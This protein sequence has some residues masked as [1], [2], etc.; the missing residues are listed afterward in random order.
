MPFW[1]LLDTCKGTQQ[2][3]TIFKKNIILILLITVIGS[4]R[5]RRLWGVYT[6]LFIL[7]AALTLH[8]ATSSFA[9]TLRLRR[10]SNGIFSLMNE[11]RT[12][13]A[14]L[15][16]SDVHDQ[17][18]SIKE[19]S[20]HLNKIV[21]SN[22]T[23]FLAFSIL[24]FATTMDEVFLRKGSHEYVRMFRALFFYIDHAAVLFVSADACHQVTHP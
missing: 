12:S 1:L 21:G 17:Y 9:R 19:L 14:S 4:F 8:N 5:S 6:D 11:V 2:A 10:G 16:W 23:C 3:G 18:K 20:N 13:S 15:K 24:Y 22:T 7:M